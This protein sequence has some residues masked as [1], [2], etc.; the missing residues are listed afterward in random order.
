M[1]DTPPVT[2][3]RRRDLT[4]LALALIVAVGLVTVLITRQ[5]DSEAETSS[6]ASPAADQS[7][8]AGGAT[9]API[10][11][12]GDLARR[13]PNDPMAMGSPT[14]PVVLIEFADLRCPFCAQFGRDTKP[15]LVDRYVDSG[16][17]R[18]EWRDMAIFGPESMAGARAARAAAAQ[19]RFWEFVT[20]IYDEAPPRGHSSLTTAT[21]REFAEKAQVPDLPRFD[22]DAASTAFDEAINA[23]LEQAQMLGIPST[24]AFSL[25]G[26]PILGAQPTEAF[27]AMIDNLAAGKSATP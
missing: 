27:T 9:M 24:P 2:K 21:L 17:L 12:L 16:V 7:V 11:P 5:G 13:Q 8:P 6:T 1:P 4:L 22:V 10:G 3:S 25:N 26:E 19:G 14:A 20:A 23:D 18:V 15:V